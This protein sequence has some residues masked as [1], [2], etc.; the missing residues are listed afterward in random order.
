MPLFSRRPRAEAPRAEPPPEPATPGVAEIMRQVRRVDLRTRGLVASQFSGEYHSVFKGQ[1]LEFV[2]VR[3]YVP[4]D[5]VRTIDWNVSARA[6]A[7]FVKKYV[8]ERE[9]TVLLAVDLSGSQRFGTRGRFKSEMVA[10]VAATLAMSAVRN[11]DR[12]GLLVFTDRIE[13]FV[14][15]RKG[16]RHVLRI[17][18]DLLAFQPAGTGTD[19]AAA[20]RHAFRVMRGRSIVFLISD[21]HLN[22]E[23]AAFDHALRS[24]AVRHD[25]IPVGLGDPAD[26]R[27]PDVGVLRLVDPETGDSVMVDTGVERVRLEFE[28][29]A[30]DERTAV[31]KTF[32]RLGLDEIELRTDQ[33]ISTAVLSFFRRRERRLRQ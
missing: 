2:E 18:R 9:L 31:R 10:E 4:G 13:A 29:A 8:E 19:V 12:V 1:G 20:L 17:I 24:A 3:E 6:G 30:R 26:A 7:T 11:N 23:Q 22:G 28:S 16:R 21:F 14:P 27:I 33:P 32:R 5:D 25:V 15:P